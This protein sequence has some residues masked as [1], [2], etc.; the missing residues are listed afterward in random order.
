MELSHEEI[1]HISTLCRI[2]LTVEDIERLQGELS[3]ILEQFTILTSLDTS[4]VS[5]TGHWVNVG[6]VM[7]SDST[8]PPFPTEEILSNAP[9]RADNFFR[10]FSVLG[11]P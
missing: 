10:V 1:E 11:E 8:T 9:D 5:E 3:L 7:R 4:K 2:G 6:S